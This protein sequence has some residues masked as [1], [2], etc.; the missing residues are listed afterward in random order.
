M[1]LTR[2]QQIAQN[3]YGYKWVAKCEGKY[4]SL[5]SFHKYSENSA[6][7]YGEIGQE[8]GAINVTRH[9]NAEWGFHIFNRLDEAKKSNWR[10]V[11]IYDAPAFER[12][13][14]KVKYSSVRFTGI[15]D[16]LGGGYEIVVAEKMTLI[17]E[18]KL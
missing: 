13:L 8:K 6:F 4:Y 14:M 2:F 7:Q 12:V 9:K 3:K 15:G 10:C 5:N 16:G 18:V 17:E 1:C 11:N